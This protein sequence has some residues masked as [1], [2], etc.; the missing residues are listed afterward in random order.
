M[1]DVT[2]N[3]GVSYK[4]TLT[5]TIKAASKMIV[6]NKDVDKIKSMIEKEK[7]LRVTV[8]QPNE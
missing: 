5:A 7:S 8:T 2:T 1:V 4:E 3:K 6:R